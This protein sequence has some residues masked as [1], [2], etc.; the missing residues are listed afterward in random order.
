[1]DDKIYEQIRG[2]IAAALIPV[3]I[4]FIATTD[5]LENN[6]AELRKVQYL[7]DREIAKLEGR[8]DPDQYIL[9]GI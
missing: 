4:D 9:E 6:V 5:G 8:P 1:M 7:I 2:A 3:A